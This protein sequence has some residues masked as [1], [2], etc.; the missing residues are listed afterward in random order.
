MNLH[1]EK[2]KG[3]SSLASSDINIF[4][5][6]IKAFVPRSFQHCNL[7]YG[8]QCSCLRQMLM[9]CRQTVLDPLQNIQ[10]VNW[11]HIWGTWPISTTFLT[12]YSLQ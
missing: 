8:S 12:E 4:L 9:L 5:M 6:A 1:E 10:L 7:Q 3:F 2:Q 11:T